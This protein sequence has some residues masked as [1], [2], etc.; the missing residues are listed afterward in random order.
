MADRSKIPAE[1]ERTLNRPGNSGD[2]VALEE[3]GVHGREQLQQEAPV[4]AAR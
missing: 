2:S 3:D 1:P 4:T